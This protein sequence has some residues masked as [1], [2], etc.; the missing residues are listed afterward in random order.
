MVYHYAGNALYYE[1]QGKGPVLV[2]LHGYPESNA[3]WAGFREKLSKK[4]TVIT[5]DLPGLGQSELLGEIQSMEMMAGAVDAL[6][7]HEKVK[8]CVMVGHSMG[9]YV[10]LA[11]ADLYPEKLA[12][13]GLF[14]SMALEDGEEAKA[15]RDRTIQ[16]IRKSKNSFLNQFFPNLFAGHNIDLFDRE[17][18][19]MKET[20]SHTS[21]EALIACMTGMKLRPDRQHV[22]AGLNVPVLFILGKH[23]SRMPVERIIPQTMLPGV[24]FTLILGNAGHMGFYEEEKLS[25]QAVSDFCGQCYSLSEANHSA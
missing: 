20:A 4:Y 14:H 17:I 11:Y 10:T 16:L 2:L 25:M 1:K 19:K 5:P 12:G 18:R 23:D 9:G 13:I 22:L 21:P 15:N 7:V 8:R 6:L 3:I 24:S